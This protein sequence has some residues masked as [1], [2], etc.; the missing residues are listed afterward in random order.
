MVHKIV[1]VGSGPAGH[2]AAIYAARANLNP[3]M[4]EGFMAGGIA[5]GGQLTTTTEVEN[6]PGFPNGIDGTQLT[7]LFREQSVKYGTKILTQTITKVDFSSR[8]FQLWSDEER[9]EAEAVII[10]TGAT[11]RRMHVTGEDTYWQRGISACAVCDGA[12]PIYRNKE[13][14]V[15]GGG[16]SAVEEASHLTKFASKVY[17]VH[18]RDSLRASKI[19]QKR[20]T[21]HPKIEIIWNSQVKEAKGDGKNL[22]ALTL[23]DT[24][25]G[26]KKELSVGG[27][28]Y[29]IGHKPNTD[30]FKG[31]LD[32]DESGYIKTVPGS[33]K[34]S[35]EGIFAAG[36]V[37]DKIYRQAVSAA[38]SGCMAALDA[39]RWLESREE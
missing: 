39:E 20:A 29:A 17:L 6:F 16:D 3:V 31:I 21:T 22:T 5:A 35:I 9:I 1:I 24:M 7:Q 10:A 33:T 37:Q 38:G 19:M 36:D 11:A 23:E 8:P 4:Y 30:I 27:L 2:T 34:T 28:F 25:S 15:V 18:R 26:Q 14:A 32:L 13:L 12:L